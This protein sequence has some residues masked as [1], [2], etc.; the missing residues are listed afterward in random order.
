[1]EGG[2]E[3]VDF[4]HVDCENEELQLVINLQ[5]KNIGGLSLYRGKWNL[6]GCKKWRKMQGN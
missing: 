5:G 6:H 2:G 3:I 4:K 1:V